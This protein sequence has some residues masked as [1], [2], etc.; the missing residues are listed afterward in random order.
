[1]NQLDYWNSIATTKTFTTD[2]KL[3]IFRA[4]VSRDAQILDVGCGYGRV[5][6]KLWADGYRHLTGIDPADNL[7]RRGQELFPH[8]RLV[9]QNNP[10][11]LDVPNLSVD[12]AALR[13]PDLRRPR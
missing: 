3:E 13:C 10:D 6:A 8:L 4:R 2:F 11:V 1:M 5:M 12:A 9:H 7:I